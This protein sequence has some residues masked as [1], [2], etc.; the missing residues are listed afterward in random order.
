[1][2]QVISTLFSMISDAESILE[3]ECSF[4][5]C[6]Y[7]KAYSHTLNSV[8]EAFIKDESEPPLIPLWTEGKGGDEHYWGL[9]DALHDAAEKAGVQIFFV[10][11]GSRSNHYGAHNAADPSR[12]TG[13][14]ANILKGNTPY[15][16]ALK[17]G[18]RPTEAEIALKAARW[19]AENPE[20]RSCALPAMRGH[21]GQCA[22][23]SVYVA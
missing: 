11:Y 10:D 19:V 17:E 18:F 6:E 16:E 7:V 20:R 3:R 1:M 23:M 15:R 9:K 14:P 4:S 2:Q 5:V 22:Y 12:W 13:W 21:Y 8:L